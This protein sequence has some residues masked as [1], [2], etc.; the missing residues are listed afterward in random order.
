MYPSEICLEKN[1]IKIYW[2]DERCWCKK[3]RFPETM[4]MQVWSQEIVFSQLSLGKNY[5]QRRL[6]TSKTKDELIL[7]T[8]IY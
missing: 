8:Q 4:H 3:I 2:V 1:K 5:S 6:P 7:I